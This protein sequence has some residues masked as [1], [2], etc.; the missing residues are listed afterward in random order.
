MTLYVRAV[1]AIGLMS[2]FYALAIAICASLVWIGMVLLQPLSDSR[3]FT[4]HWDST[5]VMAS[6]ICFFVASMIAWSVLPRFD[7]FKTPGLEVIEA[8]HPRLF[9]EILA[10]AAATGQRVPDH[11]YLISEANVFV[12]HRGGI[13]GIG[14]RRVMG[15]GLP[16][17]RTLQVNEL[18]AV[19]AHEMGHFYSG[20]VRLG[21]WIYKTRSGL[22]RTVIN[23]AKARQTTDRWSERRSSAHWF[24][25]LLTNGLDEKSWIVHWLRQV[26]AA[27]QAPFRWFLIGFMRISQAISRAQECSA[28]AMAVRV[29]GWRAFV[30]GLKKAHAAIIVH[31]IYMRTEVLPLVK[32]GAL[33]A[34]GEGFSRFLLTRKLPEFLNEVVAEELIDGAAS[35]YDSHPPLPT[36][37][38]MATSLCGPDKP[39]DPRRA[40][41]LIENADRIE[42]EQLANQA[43][44]QLEPVSWNEIGNLWIS[45]WRDEVE[46][47]RPL[48]AEIDINAIPSDLRYI[49]RLRG[50]LLG[51]PEAGTSYDEIIL[52]WS[53][54]ASAALAVL[55]LDAG[56]SMTKRL[57]EPGQ[58]TRGNATVEPFVELQQLIA[59]EISEEA[60]C[61]RWT[62][63]GFANRK[64]ATA[65]RAR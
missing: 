62:K 49:N 35:P 51:Y 50:R 34:V 58:F 22:A 48:L 17:L 40:I 33:P 61:A 31:P 59:G 16:L 64:L 18:R 26:L 9:A 4:S 1:L 20:D 65:Q 11:V 32:R 23:L 30:E 2:L 25:R 54:T 57:G 7:R 38:A 63:L 37:I 36:R 44:R 43:D 39:L 41:E 8:H 55:L 13:M 60:W 5:I 45:S 21:P 42:S 15:L 29:E 24:E 14:S 52:W 10:V 19:L 53:N 28:D 6:N 46:Q 27:T 12:T 47:A 56:F 3:S